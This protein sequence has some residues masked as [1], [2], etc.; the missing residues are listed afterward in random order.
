MTLQ[1]EKQFFKEINK[2]IHP[3]KN[4]H[5]LTK[6]SEDQ[7]TEYQMSLAVGI[8]EERFQKINKMIDKRFE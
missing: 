2:L 1:P 6:F 4:P 3:E 5:P 7:K 8:L